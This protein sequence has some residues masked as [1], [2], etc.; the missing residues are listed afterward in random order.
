MAFLDDDNGRRLYSST[1]GKFET[2]HREGNSEVKIQESKSSRIQKFKNPKVQKCRK[3]EIVKSNAAYNLFI[4]QL[5]IF[6]YLNFWI[7]E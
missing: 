4:F 2:L 1:V 3:C 7:F 6:A 5:C